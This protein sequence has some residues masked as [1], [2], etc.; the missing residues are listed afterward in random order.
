METEFSF[1]KLYVCKHCAMVH[2][3]PDCDADKKPYP[4]R[5]KKQNILQRRQRW[6]CTIREQRNNPIFLRLVTKLEKQFNEI[7]SKLDCERSESEKFVGSLNNV[8]ELLYHFCD[9][10]A[11]I[12]EH[13]SG[14]PKNAVG[15][16]KEPPHDLFLAWFINS[17]IYTCPS[18]CYNI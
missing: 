1:G 13:F 15:V 4:K 16:K 10:I 12:F 14:N 17:F 2:A 5:A 3:E 6:L 9:W 18:V 11:K 7:Q 8:D